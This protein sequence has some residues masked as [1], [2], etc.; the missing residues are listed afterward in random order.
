MNSTTFNKTDN[1]DH[2]TKLNNL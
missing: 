1:V 2:R